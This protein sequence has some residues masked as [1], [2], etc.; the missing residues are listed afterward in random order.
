[1][2]SMCFVCVSI[3][4]HAT[5]GPTQYCALLSPLST[6]QVIIHRGKA[7]SNSPHRDNQF[8]SEHGAEGHQRR[9]VRCQNGFA[10]GSKQAICRRSNR[11]NGAR[12]RGSSTFGKARL[13][14]AVITIAVSLVAEPTSPALRY[15]LHAENFS[16][17]SLSHVLEVFAI[18]RAC[19]C[20]YRLCTLSNPST[21]VYAL[22]E[23]ILFFSP[24]PRD[25]Y[26]D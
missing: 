14:I 19:P 2:Q 13:T 25:F 18:A 5:F 9:Q 23:C 10:N 3:C 7:E 12:E 20:T 22:T 17:L 21:P 8:L 4:A 24:S 6:A 1:V 16:A 15:S 11:E 26:R